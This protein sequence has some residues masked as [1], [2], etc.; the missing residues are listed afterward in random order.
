MVPFHGGCRGALASTAHPLDPRARGSSLAKIGNPAD[1]DYALVWRPEP[2]F[3][4]S[5]PSLKLILSL[6]AR[7]D[8]LLGDPQLP[9]H[10]PIVRLVDLSGRGLE[11]GRLGIYSKTM[12]SLLLSD[13]RE[14]VFWN[15]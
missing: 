1:I 7:V 6:D 13:G 3:L 15:A 5:L 11:G 4:A 12:V 2:G 9:L 8:H 10:L 14:Q